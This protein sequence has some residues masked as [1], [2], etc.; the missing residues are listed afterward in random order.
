MLNL[1]QSGFVV[2]D[3]HAVM[4]R[5]TCDDVSR[6]K[7][8]PHSTDHACAM[9]LKSDFNTRKTRF[10]TRNALYLHEKTFAVIVGF[11]VVFR[12]VS[13]VPSIWERF[14]TEKFGME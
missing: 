3:L 5:V 1:S 6:S 11:C 4:F 14:P 2:G 8:G 7:G 12:I 9:Q 10:N 13:R